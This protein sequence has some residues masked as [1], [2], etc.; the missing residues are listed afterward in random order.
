MLVLAG[1][2]KVNKIDTHICNWLKNIEQD[3]EP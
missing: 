3:D 1:D 2:T